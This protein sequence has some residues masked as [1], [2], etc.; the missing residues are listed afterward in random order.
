[1][2]IEKISGNLDV[3][4]HPENVS[5]SWRLRC[6]FWLSVRVIGFGAWISG[7]KVTIYGP[8]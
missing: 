4:F 1:M 6:R 5:L 7:L 8:Y 2:E 3:E